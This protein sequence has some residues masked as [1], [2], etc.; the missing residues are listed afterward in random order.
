M[1][2]W[3]QP[4]GWDWQEKG[5]PLPDGFR[6]ASNTN[7]QWLDLDAIRGIV[8]P[9]EVAAG[10]RSTGSNRNGAPSASGKG[11]A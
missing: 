3:N 2:F 4:F 1:G 10:P 7:T 5:R 11:H 8:A 6:Y 9:F